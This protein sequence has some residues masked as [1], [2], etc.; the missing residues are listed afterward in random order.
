MKGVSAASSP[1][2]A[3]GRVQ[4]L[5]AKHPPIPEYAIAPHQVHQEIERLK[6]AVAGAL[7]ELEEEKR[8]LEQL[9]AHEPLHI[10]EALRMLLTDPELVDASAQI[11]HAQKIN[12]EWALHKRLEQITAL[13]EKMEDPYLRG[14]KSDVEQAVK[15]IQLQLKNPQEAK[16]TFNTGDPVIL[17]GEEIGPID[18]VQCWRM[19]FSGFIS[20]AGGVDAHAVILAR[21]LGIPALFGARGIVDASHEGQ[22]IVL[23]GI[24]RTWILDPDEATLR[25]YEGQLGSLKEDEESLA[26]FAEQPSLTKDGHPI[27]IL[28]NLEVVEELEL[29]KRIGVDGIGLYRTEFAFLQGGDLPD[30]EEQLRLYRRIVRAME[31]KP[32]TFRLW[33]VGADKEG[34]FTRILGRKGHGENPAMGL[35]GVRLLLQRP[36]VLRTQLRALLRASIDGDVQILIPMVTNPMEVDA[37]RS[38]LFECSNAIGLSSLPP[39]GAMIETPSAALTASAL[40]EVCDFLSVGTNDLIQFTL[41][42]DRTDEDVAYLFNARHEAVQE[43]LQRVVDA[44]KS[45]GIPISLCGEI[46]GDP[47]WTETLIQI[48][49]ESLSM[50]LNNVLRVRRQLA[51]LRYQ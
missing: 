8:H 3:I 47:Q 13:F 17:V 51:N 50:S 48:G 1:G 49:F 28:A 27:L 19:G 42:V 40:A 32:V 45:Q 6:Q 5:H 11:I 22:L 4:K 39:L 44:A 38:H 26:T 9:D 7:A 37:V 31:G 43:L 34:M 18:I 33:D 24:R 41:A 36:D 12:A 25:Y 29:A 16:P 46:A 20:E 35:R 30:E 2:I 21:G 15:R 23:D 10:L 14:K